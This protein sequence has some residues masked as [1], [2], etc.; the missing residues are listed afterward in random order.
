VAAAILQPPYPRGKK[1]Q[2]GIPFLSI[3][4]PK[5]PTG[6]FGHHRHLH[7]Q[8]Q[9]LAACA[10]RGVS[11]GTPYCLHNDSRVVDNLLITQIRHA[12]TPVQPSLETAVNLGKIYFPPRKAHL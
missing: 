4:L 3:N 5:T 10:L 6:D 11:A 9:S 2:V 8:K 7:A 1:Q 12:Q